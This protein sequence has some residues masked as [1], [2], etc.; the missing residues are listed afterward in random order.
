MTG[1]PV[2]AAQAT[3]RLQKLGRRLLGFPRG[4]FPAESEAIRLWTSA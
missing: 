2:P 1:P 3:R 4:D